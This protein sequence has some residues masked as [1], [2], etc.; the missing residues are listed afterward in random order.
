MFAAGRVP[1]GSI[2]TAE[3][4]RGTDPQHHALANHI[5]RAD[6][7]LNTNIASNP[8]TNSYSDALADSGL[9]T[10]SSGIELGRPLADIRLHI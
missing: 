3:R 4:C 5:S 6:F 1:N 2:D 10:T 7:A 9:F 8:N